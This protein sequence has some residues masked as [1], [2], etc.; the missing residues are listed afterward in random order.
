MIAFRSYLARRFGLW[1][2]LGCLACAIAHGEDLKRATLSPVSFDRQ[3]TAKIR[4]DNLPETERNLI[5]KMPANS[6]HFGAARVGGNRRGL[7]EV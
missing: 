6:H 7:I 5:A 3:D 4:I 2:V 1:L